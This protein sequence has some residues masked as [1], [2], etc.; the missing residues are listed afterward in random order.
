MA[1]KKIDLT[2]S[3]GISSENLLKAGK[4][5][6]LT[7]DLGSL[8]NGKPTQN[9][10]NNKVLININKI[11]ENPFQ[12]RIEIKEDALVELSQSIKDEGLLQ[13]I[14]VQKYNHKYIVIAGHRRVAAMKLINEDNIWASVIDVDYSDTVENKQLLF[15]QATIENIQRENLYPLELALACKEAIDKNLYKSVTEI[16]NVINKSRTYLSKI[17]SILRLSDKIIDDLSIDKTVKDLEALYELQKIKDVDSQVNLYF[18][19]KDKKI[20]RDDIREKVKVQKNK[21]DINIVKYKCTKEKLSLS[22][23]LTK[24]DSKNASDL[25]LKIEAL[26]ES[27]L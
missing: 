17:M 24:L 27:Y 20:T 4:G 7:Q 21:K 14:V 22:I 1:K 5:A 10:T 16:A 26:I 18:L 9:V 11:I 6:A 12:P 15:R 25:E 23:D 2:N 3:I 13:P 19:F 8:L